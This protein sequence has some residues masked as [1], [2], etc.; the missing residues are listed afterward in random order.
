MSNVITKKDV[1]ESFFEA[2]N[3]YPGLPEEAY[4]MSH[5][6]AGELPE[7][8]TPGLL[9]IMFE[10]NLVLV[11]LEAEKSP[12]VS[13]RAATFYTKVP[14]FIQVVDAATPKEF[15]KEF[16]KICL[17][18]LNYDPP[19]YGTKKEEKS[20]FVDIDEWLGKGKQF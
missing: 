11:F 9:A 1:Y 20:M 19:V 15:S 18:R 7:A 13:D 6:I 3:L 4:R 10:K 8:I 5:V 12:A 17:H 16:R 14:Y 2:E